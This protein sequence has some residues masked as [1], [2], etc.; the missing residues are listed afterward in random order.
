[1]PSG[2]IGQEARRSTRNN[3]AS[4]MTQAETEL[5]PYDVPGERPRSHGVRG[6]FR[7]P[8]GPAQDL[9]DADRA[10]LL[11]HDTDP[12]NRWEQ[13]RHAGLWLRCWG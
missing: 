6:F 10:H 7:A 2:L 4:K 11:A 1:M 3:G 9:S 8:S 12:F 13:G 5:C